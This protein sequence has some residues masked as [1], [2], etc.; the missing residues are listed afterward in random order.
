MKGENNT[1]KMKKP[2]FFSRIPPVTRILAGVF[3]LLLI[4][5]VFTGLDNEAGLILGWS[6][7]TVLLAELTRRWRRI[8]NF[9]ILGVSV[10]AGA[11]FLAFMHEE[12]VY[13]LVNWLGGA[14][15]LQSVP[16]RI[17]HETVSFIILFFTPTGVAVGLVGAIIMLVVKLMNRKRQADSPK[18]LTEA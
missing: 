9:L 8:W 4:G 6:A 15:A 11:I 5:L 1:T 7:A 17:F 14:G 12:V 18:N 13:P 3:I 16:M 2:S 10:F